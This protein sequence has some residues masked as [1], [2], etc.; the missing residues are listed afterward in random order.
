MDRGEDICIVA[1]ETLKPELEAVMRARGC[2][3]PVLWV[4]SGKHIWPDKLR[5]SIQE[6]IDSVPPSCRTVLLAFGFCG[7]SM[8]GIRSASCT[9]VLPRAAD[10]IPLFLGSLARRMEYGSETYFFT[11]GYLH[12]ETSFISECEALMLRYG[13]SRGRRIMKKMLAHYR[14]I[15][16]V[17]TGAFDVPGLVD[18]IRPFASLVDIP[19]STIPGNL[20]LLDGLLA[21]GWDEGEYLVAEPGRGICFDDSLNLGAAQGGA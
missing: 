4:G 10:C 19:V 6:M 8:V 15:A 7:N 20:R 12:S 13:E 9:L 14:N 5:V 1:C 18:E 3:Y 17:D 16:V 11:E 21:G 2:D